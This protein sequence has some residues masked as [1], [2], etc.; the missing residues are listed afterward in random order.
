MVGCPTSTEELPSIGR[1][2]FDLF[3]SAMIT[4]IGFYYAHRLVVTLIKFVHSAL[5]PT[6]FSAKYVQYTNPIPM[7]PLY[8]CSGT[9]RNVCQHLRWGVAHKENM[10]FR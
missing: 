1:A 6:I 4:E 2:L 9:H 10:Q 3:C 5:F 8:F 7:H